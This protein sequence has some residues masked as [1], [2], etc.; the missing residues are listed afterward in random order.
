[1][2]PEVPGLHER[3]VT[4]YASALDDVGVAIFLF[5]GVIRPSTYEVRNYTRKHLTIERFGAVLDALCAAGTPVSMS[6]LVAATQTG[7]A[8]PPRAFIVTF[9]DGFE[10]NYSLAAPEL[11]R[12][13]VPATFYVTSG[14]VD[15]NGSSWIDIIE[16]AFEACADIAATWRDGETVV[17]HTPAEKRDA[18]DRIRKFVKTQRDVDPYALASSICEQLGVATAPDDVQLDR[19]MTWSQV[20]DLS[21]HDLFTVG[22]HGHTH[23]ILS[24]LDQEELERE[25][26]LSLE[27]LRVHV[28]RPVVH[29][30]Y[31]EGLSHCYSPAVVSTLRQHGVCCA[32][33]AEPGI[34][35]VGDDLFH[36]RRVAVI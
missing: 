19:K 10:N 15:R 8:L 33:T 14:F 25:I 16:H 9:D 11:E 35:R 12:R 28:A 32:P 23:R 26:A 27:L 30:S 31:P 1:M 21:R 13:G 18:L 2:R 6:D 3:A 34:N 29:Y 20:R 7:R 36:L 5:H 4:D 24:F 17:C 22:G